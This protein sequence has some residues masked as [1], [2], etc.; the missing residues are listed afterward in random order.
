MS[1]R[2]ARRPGGRASSRKAHVIQEVGGSSK[3]AEVIQDIGG[4]P[5]HRGHSR[6][7]A[8]SRCRGSSGKSGVIHDPGV[9]QQAGGCSGGRTNS[10]ALRL[11]IDGRPGSA[12]AGFHIGNVIA[13]DGR[14]RRIRR[15]QKQALQMCQTPF[16][17]LLLSWVHPRVT[18]SAPRGSVAKPTRCGEQ[19]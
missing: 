7:R 14:H 6:S 18:G 16:E 5:G 15:L 1:S 13:D 9:T 19:F 8:S 11:Q 2:K 3:T 4:H 17:A 10:G 12:D